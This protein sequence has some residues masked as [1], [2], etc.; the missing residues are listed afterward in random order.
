MAYSPDYMVGPGDELEEHSGD[1]K[2]K[3]PVSSRRW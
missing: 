1:G 2:K 3:G